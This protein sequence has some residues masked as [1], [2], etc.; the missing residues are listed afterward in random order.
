MSCKAP[1]GFDVVSIFISWLTGDPT[2]QISPDQYKE[3]FRAV[4]QAGEAAFQGAD[5]AD[6]ENYRSV[7]QQLLNF[8]RQG[9]GV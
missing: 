4:M 2:V 5:R 9:G 1:S 7:V 6:Y 8:G 3:L